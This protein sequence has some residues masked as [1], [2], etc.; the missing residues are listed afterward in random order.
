MIYF[1][2]RLVN[3]NKP[4]FK[5]DRPFLIIG[6]GQTFDKVW[7]L[8]LNKF[9]TFGL[10]HVCEHLK[11]DIGHCIDLNVLSAEFVENSSSVLIPWHPHIKFR[12]SKDDLNQWACRNELLTECLNKDKLYYYNSSTYKGYC[13]FEN[14]IIKVKFFSG[15]VPFYILGLCGVKRIFSLGIDGGTEYSSYFRNLIPLQ[16]GRQSFDESIKMIYKSC[17]KFGIDWIRL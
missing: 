15:E 11:C 12:V 9:Y 5:Q 7:G 3:A 16:N 10:N 17:D 13:P 4:W 1:L 8:D 14:E 6:K 2:S